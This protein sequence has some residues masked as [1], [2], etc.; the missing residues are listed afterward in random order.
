MKTNKG[1]IQHAAFEE[2]L[3]K[4]NGARFEKLLHRFN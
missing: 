3:A 4:K 2:G 1:S